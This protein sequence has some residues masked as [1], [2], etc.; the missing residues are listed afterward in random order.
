MEEN[1]I[2]IALRTDEIGEARRRID[3]AD[4]PALRKNV[5]IF[6][7]RNLEDRAVER[8]MSFYQTVL[9]GRR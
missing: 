9:D 3:E 2:G 1:G 8:L 5:E 7:K 4:Y 6:R